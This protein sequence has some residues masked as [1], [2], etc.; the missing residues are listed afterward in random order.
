V[1]IDGAGAGPVSVTLVDALGRVQGVVRDLAGG[2]QVS[3]RFAVGDLPPGVYF[4]IAA[5]RDAVQLRKFVK[6]E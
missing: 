5:T 4:I 2:G 3:H 6:V 1:R